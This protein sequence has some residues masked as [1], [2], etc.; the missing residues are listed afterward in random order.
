MWVEGAVG[1]ELQAVR[2]IHIFAIFGDD[3]NVK[4][5]GKGGC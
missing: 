1:G 3:T 5:G 4:V 2:D